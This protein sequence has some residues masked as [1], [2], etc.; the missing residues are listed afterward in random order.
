MSSKYWLVILAVATMYYTA[1]AQSLK[2]LSGK[3]NSIVEA[4]S[5]GF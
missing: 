1:W 2:M 5:S 3:S 4:L